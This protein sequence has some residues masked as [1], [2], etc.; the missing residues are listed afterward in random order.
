MKLPLLRHN[1][2]RIN[3]EYYWVAGV[4]SA[5]P[6]RYLY[7]TMYAKTAQEAAAL[8]VAKFGKLYT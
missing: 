1:W 2:D 5:G 8:W 6:A 4:L 7:A 3:K